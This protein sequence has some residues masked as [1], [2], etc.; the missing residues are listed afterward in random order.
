[1]HTPLRYDHYKILGIPRNASPDRVK[2][3]YRELAKRYHP[4]RSDSPSAASRFQLLHTAYT[5]LSD[6]DR[7]KSYDER[8]QFYRRKRSTEIPPQYRPA[9]YRSIYRNTHR[10]FERPV[11]RFA[12]VGLHVTG[13][14]FGVVLISG[15]LIGVTFLDWPIY[16]LVLCIPGIVVIPDSIAGLRMK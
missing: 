14:C 9:G 11:N 6:P 10:T 16:I 13:L 12:F 5:E 3:A 8:L 2:R 1:M 7:R 4:D 15:I